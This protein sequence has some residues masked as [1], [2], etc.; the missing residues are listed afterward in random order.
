MGRQHPEAV[1]PLLLLL[2]LK[3]EH[4]GL[5]LPIRK[6]HYDLAR[7]VIDASEKKKRVRPTR[8]YRKQ[9][10]RWADKVE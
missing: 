5:P 10:K 2:D 4:G 7:R 6:D 9:H 8:T 1:E 3:V